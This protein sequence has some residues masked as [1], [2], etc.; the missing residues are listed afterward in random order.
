MRRL[1]MLAVVTAAL[2]LPVA[3][4][5]AHSDTSFTL[6]AGAGTS[7]ATEAMPNVRN[8]STAMPAAKVQTLMFRPPSC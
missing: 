2:A 3:A 8:A 7:A 4:F 6:P 5:A 1:I